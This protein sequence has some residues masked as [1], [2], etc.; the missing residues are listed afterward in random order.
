MAVGFQRPLSCL[1][2]FL[3]DKLPPL[4]PILTSIVLALALVPFFPTQMKAD[5]G[6][7][8]GTVIQNLAAAYVVQMDD[9]KMLEV[10]WDSGYDE[11]SAGNRVML[12][13]ESGEGCMYNAAERT[14]V[15]VFP[16]DPSEIGDQ[17]D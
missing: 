12:K 3:G 4:K 2:I 8:G 14:E 10:D 16:Y 9:G 17:E 15:E 7:Y 11:W 13:T 1:L 5:E 6:G